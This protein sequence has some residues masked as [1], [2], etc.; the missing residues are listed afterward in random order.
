MTMAKGIKRALLSLMLFFTIFL[1]YQPFY[2]ELKAIQANENLTNNIVGLM[3]VIYPYFWI[4]MGIVCMGLTIYFM[5]D[6]MG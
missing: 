3:V 6:E 1:S 4:M 2:A 5:A